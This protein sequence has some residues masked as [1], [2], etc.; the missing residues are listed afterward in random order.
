M[1]L[2][3]VWTLLAGCFDPRPPVFE[4][5]RP[6]APPDDA[7]P[8]D[9]FSYIQLAPGYRVS[10]HQDF[11]A[12]FTFD[13]NDFMEDTEV[14]DNQ[15]RYLF[16]L[17]APFPSTI[18]VIAGRE[19]LLLDGESVEVHDFGNHPRNMIGQADNLTG[20]V[21]VPDFGGPSGPAA[22]VVSSSS[23]DGGDGLF[24]INTEWGIS[25]DLVQNNTRSV[26]YDPTGAF[27]GLNGPQRYLGHQFGLIRRSDQAVIAN[28]GDYRS[29]RL[30]GGTMYVTKGVETGEQ[31]VTIAST[32]HAQ[33]VL[34]ERTTLRLADGIALPG[35]I[36]WAIANSSQLVL[37][38]SDGTLDVVAE[39][40]DPAYLWT[41]A[42]APP[43]GHPQ[44][45]RVYVLE[46][47]RGN[48]VDRVL[49]I[50]LP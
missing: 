31:L 49:A 36:A 17:G 14:H 46:S 35:S 28:S 10:L 18:G 42:T 8:V 13:A 20:A 19:I 41:S 24:A 27:D 40:T 34:A 26:L 44:A 15:P 32:T 50:D 29:M 23:E 4:E 33:I 7:P 22:L 45:G 2:L 5:P 25:Q 37:V 12:S 21:L 39:L 38:R 3:F 16:S 48:D 6:D 9:P 47:H 43:A 11:S 1:R 30:V